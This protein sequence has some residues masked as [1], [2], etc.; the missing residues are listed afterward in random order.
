VIQS[1]IA[2]FEIT[3]KEETVGM[4]RQAGI[5]QDL[6]AMALLGY[7]AQKTWINAAIA[8]IQAQLGHRG[9]GRPRGAADGAA[10]AKRTM[11]AAARRR[12]GAAQRKRWAAVRKQA[13]SA[14]KP[15]VPKKRKLSAAGRK[16]I[17]EATRKRWAAY[18]K[19]GGKKGKAGAK[20]AAS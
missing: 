20:A 17:I 5:D 2:F 18:R 16:A 6:L 15:A 4:A 12:I 3:F 14:A 7:E 10:S 9:P 13:K 11:S 8:D 1:Q 19:A